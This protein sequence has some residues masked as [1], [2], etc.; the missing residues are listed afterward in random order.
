MLIVI[1]KY[2]YDTFGSWNVNGTGS[3]GF[4]IDFFLSKFLIKS[5]CFF[6]KSGTSLAF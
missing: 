5:S 1:R 6:A 4:T 3:V 2:N